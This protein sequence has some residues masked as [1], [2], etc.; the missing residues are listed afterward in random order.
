MVY[1]QC[2]FPIGKF[3]YRQ[4]L[5]D[6]YLR[7][8]DDNAWPP[9]K[10]TSFINLAL[11]KDQTSWRET[12]QGSIDEIIGDKEDIAYHHLL[13]NLPRI[14]FVLFEGRPG[15]GKTTL[16]TKISRDWANGLLLKSELLFLIPL[17]RLNTFHN[18]T[19]TTLIKV[20]CPPFEQD[21]IEAL[22]GAIVKM[23]G[24]NVVFAFD[25][26]DEYSQNSTRNDIVFDLLTVCRSFLRDALIVVSSRPAACHKF[27]QSAGVRTE[28]LGFKKE[29]IIQYIYSY[30][31]DSK[32][33]AQ[34]LIKNL[35][36]HPNLMNM[37]Y[38]PLHCAMLVFLYDGTSILPKTE[39]EF[40]KHFT[41]STL[42][43]S[44]HKR[45][46][47]VACLTSFDQLPSKDKILFDKI[48]KL[49]FDATFERKQV[50]KSSELQA[51][52]IESGSTGSDESS[53]GLVVIDRYFM[54]YGLDETYT[55]LHLTFQE[56]LAAVHMAGLQHSELVDIVKE[57]S[58]E[59]QNVV[60]MFLCGMMN[61]AHPSAVN[62]FKT[63]DTLSVVPSR[64]ESDLFLVR[65]AYESQQ[66]QPY[67]Y[68]CEK[69]NGAVQFSITFLKTDWPTHVPAIAS[70]LNN[71]RFQQ[72]VFMGTHYPS[73]FKNTAEAILCLVDNKK[74]SVELVVW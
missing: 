31:S 18:R 45:K 35:E 43:R 59:H 5:A 41:L 24:K 60:Y 10:V 65:C 42:L 70:F 3:E 33:K 12:V 16:M 8:V 20:A 25:G 32:K 69:W 1:E 71:P 74:L 63:I 66:Q 49:A 4:T 51:I 2:F 36:Q 7:Q 56:Y 21:E 29:H 17:R 14:K 28:V 67:D 11:I 52:S 40:Y 38:L 55:F 61:Y 46:G 26:L 73:M 22:E 72:A 9:V 50:F 19:L 57:R 13:D 15:S 34:Q 54:R 6:F 64:T 44:F 27:R 53:L 23:K 47:T 39:T 58:Q 37:C 62:V 68:L 48:C 30:F